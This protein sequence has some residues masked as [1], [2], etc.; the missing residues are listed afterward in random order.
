MALDLADSLELGKLTT[1]ISMALLNNNLERSDI[2]FNALE[3]V[4]ALA[5]AHP[6][7][8]T[9]GYVFGDGSVIAVANQSEESAERF[10]IG[11]RDHHVALKHPKGILAV[12]H[13]HLNA[14]RLAEADLRASHQLRIPYL[15]F[16]LGS[17]GFDFYDPN[18]SAPLSGRPWD[19]LRAN[20][21]TVVRD[22]YKQ[23]LQIELDMFW[24]DRSRK[25]DPSYNPILENAVSQGFEVL[26][27]AVR[28][29]Q[30]HD[31]LVFNCTTASPMHCAVMTDVNQN[32]MLHHQ[33]DQFSRYDLLD[34]Y[35][36]KQGVAILRY[37]GRG[38][39]T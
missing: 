38:S 37:R 34:G 12:W 33:I 1:T 36:I 25:H 31:F 8:E 39:R 35:W 32:M 2:S 6:D 11:A 5:M 24:R 19:K 10:L 15:V 17:M 21:Y 3:S 23:V 27:F 20:C 29:I 26:P 9:C 14:P 13:S 28:D 18:Y 30:N 7:V 16:D 22:Y 4:K